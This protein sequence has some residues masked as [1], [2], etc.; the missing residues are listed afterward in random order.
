MIVDFTDFPTNQALF[1]SHEPRRF[2]CESHEPPGGLRR[3]GG[4]MTAWVNM[5]N[6]AGWG[7][8]YTHTSHSSAQEA[9]QEA[10]ELVNRASTEPNSGLRH[11]D[12]IPVCHTPQESLAFL[13]Y[14]HHFCWPRWGKNFNEIHSYDFLCRKPNDTHD[15]LIGRGFPK[16]FLAKFVGIDILDPAL[17][18]PLGSG[19]VSPQRGSAFWFFTLDDVGGF[20]GSSWHGGAAVAG[21]LGMP[22]GNGGAVGVWWLGLAATKNCQTWQ[23][24]KGKLILGAGHLRVDFNFGHVTWAAVR[25]PIFEWTPWNLKQA[26]SHGNNVHDSS[27]IFHGGLAPGLAPGPNCWQLRKWTLQIFKVW[28]RAMQFSSK[29]IQKELQFHTVPFLRLAQKLVV[30]PS[31]ETSPN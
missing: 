20:D 18:N 24:H 16:P 11:I 6:W 29:E 26:P 10:S 27:N 31:R 7:A 15:K 12:P 4:R 23:T 17:G 2:H 14:Y 3:R 30:P 22:N 21:D 19:R 8:G 13:V 9:G 28:G 25:T 5:V 1:R